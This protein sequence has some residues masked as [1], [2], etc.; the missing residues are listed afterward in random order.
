MGL[1]VFVA[2]DSIRPFWEVAHAQG[3]PKEV[4]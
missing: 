2:T 1:L 4:R 3:Q